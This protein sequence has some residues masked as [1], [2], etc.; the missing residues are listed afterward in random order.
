MRV[1][2][3]ELEKPLVATG[4]VHF[5]DAKDEIYRRILLAA[6]KFSDADRENPLYF[7]TTDEMLEEFAYLGRRELLR[8]RGD[9]P[10]QAIA[11]DVRGHTAAAGRALPAEDRE[12]RRS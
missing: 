9:E 2:R 1:L 6:K 8:G 5:L 12:L 10:Q 11:G 4:D 3:H 7:R